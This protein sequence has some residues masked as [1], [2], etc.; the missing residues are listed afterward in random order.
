M[1]LHPDDPLLSMWRDIYGQSQGQLQTHEWRERVFS[2]KDPFIMPAEYGNP[3][4]ENL[5]RVLYYK[6]L[7]LLLPYK[8]L[9]VQSVRMWETPN[10]Y[11]D[12]GE[13]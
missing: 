12:Y 6:A 10:C 5:A 11:A 8:P 7:D 1:L 4:A 9:R 3:T 2:G 13:S